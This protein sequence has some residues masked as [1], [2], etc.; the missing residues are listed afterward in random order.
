M[1]VKTM[2]D[3]MTDLAKLM[4]K[5]VSMHVGRAALIWMVAASSVSMAATGKSVYTSAPPDPTAIRVARDG[6]HDD[7]QAIQR[8]IDQARNNGAGGVVF[9]PSG[10]YTITKTI[11]VWPA[12]RIFGVGPTRPVLELPDRTPGF[13]KGVAAMVVFTGAGPNPERP[14]VFPVANSV[15][16]NESIQ[17]AKSATFLSALSNVDIRIGDGNSGAVGVRFHVAQHAFLSH[18]NFNLG[19]GLAGV[20]QVGNEAE[21]LHFV[22]G[23]YG[24]LTEKTSPAWQFTL[25]DSTFTGQREAAIREHEAGLTLANVQFSNTPIAIDIDRGYG[26]WLWGKNVHFQNV[27]RAAVLISN[28][29]SAYTQVGFENATAA[30]VPVFA[31]FRESGKTV[32]GRGANYTVKSF[33]HG[34][35]IPALGQMGHFETQMD[36]TASP[37]KPQAERAI[38]QLPGVNEWT[39]VKSLGAKGDG[40][41]D[42]TQA[43]LQAIA[44]H[45]VLYF[46][47]GRYLVSDTLL[48]QPDTVLIG[49]HP[50]QTQIVLAENTERFSGV[51]APKALIETPRGGDNIVFGLG[52]FTGGVNPR[53]TAVMWHAGANSLMSDVKIQGGHGTALATGV[54]MDPY[55]AN[56]SAD[57][58]PRNRWNGQYPSIWVKD[59]GGGTFFAC[60]TPNTYA[61]SGF[62]VSD[63][64]TPGHVYEI[65]AEHHVRNELV[66]ERV[67]N[68][69]FLA[70]QTEEEYGESPASVSLDIRNSA[71]ILFANYHGYRV[72][73]SIAPAPAAVK[74]QNSSNI[75]FR[76]VHVNAESGIPICDA[77]GCVNFL[78]VSRYPYENAIVDATS[79]V[80]E[81]EREFAVLDVTS[82][83]ASVAPSTF[84][85]MRVQLLNDDF[86]ALVSPTVDAQGRLYFIDRDD[87]RI[88]RWSPQRRLEVVREFPLDPTQI[89]FDRSGHLLVLSTA[90]AHGTVYSFN[91]DAPPAELTVIPPTPVSEHENALVALPENWWVNGEFE[92]QLDAETYEFKT[93][94]EMFVEFAG[95]PKAREYVSPD[96]SLVLP[97]FRVFNQGPLDFNG[98]RWSAA[99]QAHGL[100]TGK[101]GDR[102]YVTNESEDMTYS[103]EIGPAGTLI[104]LKP[105]ANRGG[106]AVVADPDGRVYVA[107][108]QIFVYDS[109]GQSIGRIDVPERPIG[110]VFG[111]DDR[112]TLYVLSQHAIYS[113]TK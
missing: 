41:T 95:E 93:L 82:P 35:V 100:V 11:F 53:A 48:L 101:V 45:R 40:T 111:G 78:R 20:Y 27:S 85:G 83:S 21:D 3:S 73:R 113:V 30:N 42:D 81:R 33:S 25:V 57:G 104:N 58:D 77:S 49:L 69:E 84:D 87:P 46:P 15:P 50:S 9:L 19:S 47:S 18:M 66:L 94:A 107:N 97:A 96:G 10:R 1:K 44:T 32:A 56:H 76:N 60:W 72:T 7:T 34:L 75:R 106:E 39:S 6:A 61:H 8:A 88:Y 23:R 79:G 105:F 24:I 38:R 63:T 102:I 67:S 14:P 22:G 108:G 51:G 62:Y 74:I 70:F 43:L 71:N 28:E 4:G 5:R 112:R 68:W 109:N 31:R 2:T 26:D 80:Q 89:A 12:V 52:V 90:G 98:W 59:G 13:D 110:L 92:D 37:A 86:H 16:F 29:D 54:R 55:N 65:S 64:S 99:M 17:D 91:P 36:A 103:G